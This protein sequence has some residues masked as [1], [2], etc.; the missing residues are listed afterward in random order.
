MGTFQW[1]RVITEVNSFSCLFSLIGQKNARAKEKN[2]GKVYRA[3]VFG[4][5]QSSRQSRQTAHTIRHYSVQT[6]DEGVQ[7][8]LSF[9]VACCR[10]IL[11]SYCSYMSFG[12]FQF[13]LCK[14]TQK[15]DPPLFF[16][17][18]PFLL[19]VERRQGVENAVFSRSLIKEYSTIL[20]QPRTTMVRAGVQQRR[21]TIEMDCGETVEVA[22]MAGDLS[23]NAFVS[24]VS[25]QPIR[26][27]VFQQDISLTWSVSDKYHMSELRIKHRRFFTTAKNSFTSIH[28]VESVLAQN[29]RQFQNI[30]R[31]DYIYLSVYLFTYLPTYLPT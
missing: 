30:P 5:C 21:T 28:F 22:W 11:R 23:T 17:N 24:R 25:S 6:K 20:V 1:Y 18:P 4:S 13:L 9:R 16:Q 15:L 19:V 14:S 8:A 12:I 31:R 29:P 10:P 2:P 7:P 26:L 3:L 27:R